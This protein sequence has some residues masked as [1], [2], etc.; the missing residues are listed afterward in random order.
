MRGLD[1]TGALLLVALGVAAAVAVAAL[2]DRGY[3]T[4]WELVIGVFVGAAFLAIGLPSHVVRRRTTLASTAPPRPP[5][6]MRRTPPRAATRK[7]RRCTTRHFRTEGT[8]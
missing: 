4:P 3:F 6:N 2:I 7:P 8:P 1:A 5:P